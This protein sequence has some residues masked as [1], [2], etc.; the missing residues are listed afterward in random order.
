MSTA[1]AATLARMRSA[2]ARAS[3]TSPTCA[4]R[5]A[6]S[7]PPNRPTWSPRRTLSPSRCAIAR[8]TA[9]PARW[10]CVSLTCLNRSRSIIST[11]T[12]APV[13]CCWARSSCSSAWVCQA[14]ALSRPVFGSVRAASCNWCTST[15]RCRA[16]AGITMMIAS[17]GPVSMTSAT[18]PPSS[19]AASSRRL[20]PAL[21]ASSRQ[22]RTRV[23]NAS[24]PATSSEF[25]VNWASTAA[26][27]TARST[28][29][30]PPS[31]SPG[32]CATPSAA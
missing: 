11:P 30:P 3:A 10:P 14:D 22:P 7:S 23:V 18:Q 25:T 31:R 2:T 26:T 17:T 32:R 4:S 27:S 8:S 28:H 20:S 12:E 1:S 16:T 13:R 24:T 9:S 21:P 5:T 15:L 6:N 29:C 19:N